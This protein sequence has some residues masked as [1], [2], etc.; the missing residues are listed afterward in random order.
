MKLSSVLVF[1]VVILNAPN[2]DKT[3][4][5]NAF[6]SNSLTTINKQLN[7]LGTEK[8]STLRNAYVGALTMKRSQFE[9]AP[10]EKI[11]IF[12]KGK[13]LLER[14]ISSEPKNGEYRFLRLVIQENAPKILKYN[15]NISEDLK[16]VI[17]QYSSLDPSVKK[18]VNNFAVNSI[19]LSSSKLK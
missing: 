1:I 9:K 10:K 8:G 16:I 17:E 5:Y 3:S 12:K 13:V 19:N 2:F 15:S 14:S 11:S 6:E 18:A 7:I 4:F